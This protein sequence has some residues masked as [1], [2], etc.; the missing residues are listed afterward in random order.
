[1]KKIYIC[2]IWSFTLTTTYAQTNPKQE[3]EK[4]R[5]RI[6]ETGKD[7]NWEEFDTTSKVS[8]NKIQIELLQGEWKAYN[9]LFKFEGSVNSMALTT[10]LTIEFKENKYRRSKESKFVKFDLT[11]NQ[12]VSKKENDFGVIN[13]VT[14]NLI[15]I[16]WKN[17]DNYTRYYY[18]R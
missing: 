15:V 4:L 2:L 8:I 14:D 6:T 1:M 7:I 9:G 18:E 13:K 16:T 3:I 12:I 17:G 11:N 10:A 5:N